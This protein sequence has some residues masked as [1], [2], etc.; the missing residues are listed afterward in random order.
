[1]FTCERRASIAAIDIVTIEGCVLIVCLRSSSGPSKQIFV[2]LL[3]NV[4]SAVSKTSFADS[5]FS[6]KSFPMP[7]A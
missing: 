5:K 1:M 7:T 2:M 3:P 6:Y 4:E